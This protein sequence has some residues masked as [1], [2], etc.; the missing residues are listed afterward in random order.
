MPL[1][2]KLLTGDFGES[3]ADA[4]NLQKFAGRSIKI[5]VEVTLCPNQNMALVIA[6][7][8]MDLVLSVFYVE[9]FRGT[10]TAFTDQLEGL[11]WPMELAPSGFLLHSVEIVLSKYFRALR[12]AT[13]VANAGLRDIS[14]SVN[15]AAQL[16]A[17]LQ[18]FSSTIDTQEKLGEAMAWYQL[19]ESR[20]KVSHGAKM[21]APKAKMKGKPAR[22]ALSSP[23]SNPDMVCREHFGGQL[24]IVNPKM[25]H[26][27]AC[28]FG[29][30][31]RYRHEDITTW[32]Q[33]KKASTATTLALRFCQPCI[34]AL[35]KVRSGKTRV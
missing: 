25:N 31:C 27:F 2:K 28:A 24:R 23:G 11:Q 4:L 19:Q 35:G 15:C 34:D 18:K 1:L 13:T 9:A 21:V 29:E 26:T 5:P 3:T 33:A 17:V 16:S 14:T 30:S 22:L 8:S 7:R 6:F 12:M 20:T 32:T 10:T